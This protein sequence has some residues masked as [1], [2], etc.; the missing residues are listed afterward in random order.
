MNKRHLPQIMSNVLF[1]TGW[2]ISD[3]L[4]VLFAFMGN[5]FT[6][7]FVCNS[8]TSRR[9]GNKDKDKYLCHIYYIG[10]AFFQ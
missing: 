7:L 3:K 2:E 4:S 1:K 5:E 9:L 10:Q 8:L 6:N